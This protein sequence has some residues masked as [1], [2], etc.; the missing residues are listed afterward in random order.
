MEIFRMNQYWSLVVLIFL[1]FGCEEKTDWDY[2]SG[3][4]QQLAITAILSDEFKFQKIEIFQSMN[5]PSEDPIAITNATVA[6][7]SMNNVIEFIHDNNQPGIYYSQIAFSVPSNINIQLEILHE[8]QTYVASTSVGKVA[9]IPPLQIGTNQATDERFVAKIADVYSPV[10]QAMYEVLIDWSEIRPDTFNQALLY[11]FT[12][13]TV[14]ISGIIQP[15]DEVINFPVGTTIIEK[16]F[17]LTSD[18]ADFLRALAIETSWQGGFFDESQSS[19]KSNISN[20]ALGYFTA[21]QVLSD[22]IIVQ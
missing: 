2:Q 20:N 7:K 15:N 4:H 13:N 14:D 19:L 11:A 6:I 9:P 5:L 8:G 21:C 22:T 16:K 10:E 12:F 1:S 18:Y 3:D 17:G